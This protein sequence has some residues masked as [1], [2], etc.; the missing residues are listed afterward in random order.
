VKTPTT[1]LRIAHCGLRITV[2]GGARFCFLLSAFC[3]LACASSAD[4]II[5]S[6]HNLSASGPGT[7]KAT[8]ETEICIFCHTPHNSQPD[9]PLWNHADSKASY[10]PYTSTTLRAAVGQPEGSSKLCLSCHDGTVA[11]GMVRSQK[12]PIKFRNGVTTLPKGA[13]LIGTDLS[14]DHPVS[15][16]YDSALVAKD[17]QLHDP[18]TLKSGVRLDHKQ[19]VQCTSCHDPHNDRFGKFLVMDNTASSLCVQCHN[20]DGWRSSA[21]AM[22]GKGWNGLGLNPW[23]HSA[24]KTVADNA[25]ENCHAPHA[26]GQGQR[27]MNYANDEQNCLTCHSGSV[28]AKNV[29]TEFN[30]PSAHPVTRTSTF[31]DPTEDIVNPGTRHVSCSDCHNPHAANSSPAM[32]PN[33]SGALAGVAGLNATGQRLGNVGREYELCFRCHA[34]SLDRGRARVNRQFPETNTRL[35]FSPSS[36]SS[37]PIIAAGRNPNVPSL[38]PPW[39]ASS[40]MYCTDCHNNNQSPATGAGGPNGPHGSLYAP[41]L[42]RNLTTSDFGPESAF[43]YALCYKCHDRNRFTIEYSGSYGPVSKL[44]VLHVKGKQVACTTCHDPHGVSGKSHL[45]N[46]NLSYVQPQGG[47]I[48][49]RDTGTFRGSCTLSCHGHAHNNTG[50]PQ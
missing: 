8:A 38:L 37:H 1:S 16:T 3:L 25:C 45:M 18:Q 9:T 44:H 48:E 4:S 30:K 20:L 22:S 29:A 7:L 31:H 13:T 50:Y 42:E 12:Q 34:D 35:E 39:T 32:R 26:A 5:N 24:G 27:L 40:L 15:F 41:L 11:L 46:F 6:K 14:D 28:A 2:R 10:L 23:P 17:G 21:H 19:Q 43:Q 47:L 33:A 49:F 36:G